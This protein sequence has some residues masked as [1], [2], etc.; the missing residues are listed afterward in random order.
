MLHFDFDAS[1]L[2]RIADE[3]GATE[4]QLKLAYGRALRRTASRLKTQSR[5]GLRERLD[6]RSAAELRRRMH[7]FRFS[8]DKGAG[9]GGVRMWF[10]LNDLRASA[11]KGR[12]KRTARGAEMA[13]R[14]VPSG[15]VARNRKGKRTIMRRTT[16]K[17]YP[18]AEAT[19]GIEDEA[20]TFIED[21]VLDEVEDVFFRNF[22]AEIRA[23]TIYEVG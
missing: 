20:Q 1:D 8:R 13:G 6:L 19:L 21:E 17:R 22:R 3:F 2:R 4:K 16:P 10:G 7:G 5:K 9:L 14:E 11:F 23:R 12:P 18:I 15:F